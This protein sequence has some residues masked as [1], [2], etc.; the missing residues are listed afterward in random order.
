[1]PQIIIRGMKQDDIQAI[2]CGLVDELTQII[3]CPRD[4]FTVEAPATV[5]FAE[6]VEG[7]VYPLVQVNWFDRGQAM[8]DSVATAIDRHIRKAGYDH[9]EV[10]FIPLAKDSY[11]ENGSHF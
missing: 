8:R 11:Y 9:V 3:G 2:H 10:F 7:T 6:G 1:M 5:F 4:Y